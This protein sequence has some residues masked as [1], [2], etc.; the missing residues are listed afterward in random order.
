MNLQ[1]IFGKLQEMKQK[2][3]EVQDNLAH[4]RAHG[5]SGGGLVKATVNGLKQVVHLEIDKS[6]FKTPEDTEMISDLVI[7]AI[8]QALQNAEEKSREEL[9]KTTA[10]FLPNLPGI[11]FF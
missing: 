2:M 11:N 4:L 9:Q 10:N 5:E 3:Q 1:E 6:L 8:N 7:A